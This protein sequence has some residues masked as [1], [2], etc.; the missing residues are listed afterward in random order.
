MQSIL[1]IREVKQSAELYERILE[2]EGMP[3]EFPNDERVP[4]VALVEVVATGPEEP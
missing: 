3:A 1:G 4:F 2:A